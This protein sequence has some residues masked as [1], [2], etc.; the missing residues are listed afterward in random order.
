MDIFDYSANMFS[1]VGFGG[2]AVSNP[3]EQLAK[4]PPLSS[5][6]GNEGKILTHR[7]Q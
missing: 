2:S 7:T 4:Y 3:L 1:L 6:I 5:S